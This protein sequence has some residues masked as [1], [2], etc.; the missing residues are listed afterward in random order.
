MAEIYQTQTA[1]SLLRVVNLF[2]TFRPHENADYHPKP[3]EI[4]LLK[5]D[6]HN[7]IN[8]A[9]EMQISIHTGSLQ[10]KNIYEKLQVH[11]KTEAF[12]KAGCEKIV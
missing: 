1:A 11:S 3:Q 12:A 6:G 2:R 9:G 10:L 4:S 7:N 5:F 8:A